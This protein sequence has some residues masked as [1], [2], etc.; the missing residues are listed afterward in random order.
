MGAEGLDAIIYFTAKGAWTLECEDVSATKAAECTWITFDK[1]SGDEGQVTLKM[2]I[3][4]NLTTFQ[5]DAVIKIK[6]G[7]NVTEIEVSQE[8]ISYTVMNESDVKDFAKYY[9]PAEFA[10]VDM[11]RSDAKWS[12]YRSKQSEHFVVFWE[13]GFGDDPNGSDVPSNLRVDI[14]D[15]LL[16]AE[17]FFKTNV[18]VLKFAELGSGKSNLDKYKMQIYM[19]YQTEWLATGGGYDDVIGALWVNPSTCQPVGSTIAHEIGHSFQY[20]VYCDKIQ[21]GATNNFKHGF[22][23]G[24]EGSNGGNG[25]WEQCAQWQ[26]YQDYPEQIFDNYHFGVWNENYHRHFGHEWMRYASYWLQFY[27]SEKHGI[28]V[29]GEVWRQSYSP[30]DPLN[31]YIRVYCNNDLNVFYDEMFDYAVRM[32]TYDIKG[33]RERADSYLGRFQTK[34]YSSPDNYYQVAY[35]SCPGTTGFNVITLNVPEAGT[36]VKTSFV[37]INPGSPL[38]ANDPGQY[39]QDDAV[40]GTTTSYNAIS[41]GNPGWRYGFAAHLS[42]GKRVYSEFHADASKEIEFTVPSNTA[43]LYFVVMGAPTKYIAHPWDEKELN[44]EQWPYKVKFEN[45]DLLGTITID[46]NATPQDVSLEYNVSFPAADAYTGTTVDLMS[47][48]GMAKI[49]QAFVMQPTE[50]SGITLS[51]GSTPQEGKI[52]FGALQND[53]TLAYNTTANGYGFW[54]DSNGSVIAWGKDNDSKVFAELDLSSFLFT[55][56]QYPSKSVAGNKYSVSPVLVYTKGGV[57]YKAVVKFNITIN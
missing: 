24:F 27:W 29:V 13:A 53:G 31:T 54:F 2:F 43:K 15:L 32:S 49:A 48:G 4:E 55:V 17:K 30:E 7:K 25:F 3:K 42:D 6:S 47:N 12:W 19:L 11:L 22:R 8:S 14:D 21:Q 41:M 45:T 38:H 36:V 52:A 34:L 37:G 26:S 56:G 46:E 18:E 16:K 5:R 51:A 39:K 57:Q 1:K 23:Y 44:D 10:K 28:D 50:I 40:K 33:L 35:A 9:K 20:Q